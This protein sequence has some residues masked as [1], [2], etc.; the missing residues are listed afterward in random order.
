MA[1]LPKRTLIELG[2]VLLGI[3]AAALVGGLSAWSYPLARD[4]I[5]L[6]AYVAMAATVAMGIGP[7][8]RAWA[9]D[10]PAAPDTVERND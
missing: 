2:Y 10:R 3:G 7:L 8:M 1:D 9:L 6:V 4:D 5:W